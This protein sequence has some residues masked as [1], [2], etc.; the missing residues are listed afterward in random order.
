M[1]QKT[2]ALSVLALALSLTASADFSYTST[3]KTT[4]GSMAAMVGA[5]ADR[6]SKYYFK[7]Q[8]MMMSSGDTATV[9]D[10]AAQ[11]ITTINNAQKTY[12]VKKFSDLTTAA[13]TMDVTMDVKE[14]GQ[15]KMVNGFNATEMIVTMNMDMDMGRGQAMKMQMEM[16]MWVSPDVPGAGEMR[17]FY[18]K[19]AANFP[20][21]A[22]SEGGGNPSIQ[23]AMAQMQRKMAE[24]NGA[25]VEQVI[26]VKSAT[27]AGGAAAPAMPQMS[28]QQQAQMGAAMAQLQAMA[29]QGGPA[30]AAAQQ[31]MGRMGG[32][33]GGGA[34][35][36]SGAMIELTM[37]AGGFSSAGVPDSVFAIPDGFKP[38]K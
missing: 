1:F 12:V 34:A 3:M 11:T 23:K 13:G 4:G 30:G 25:V 10:F 33:A 6:T 37:D 7:G 22:L 32:M 5:A 15:K 9:M 18:K 28:A 27:D 24:L 38:G 35:G 14:T 31:A 8:K 26:R 2:A 21:S 36:G 20:W 17:D 29:K 16:D 19:N